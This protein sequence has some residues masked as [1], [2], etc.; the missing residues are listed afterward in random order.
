M[1]RDRQWLFWQVGGLGPMAGQ[2]HH[3][4][5]CAPEKIAYGGEQ[6]RIR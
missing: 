1:G 6:T 5:H 4:T 2:N 3:F